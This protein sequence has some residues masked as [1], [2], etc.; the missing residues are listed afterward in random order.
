MAL[1]TL[2]VPERQVLID[3][4]GDAD[5]YNWHH[6]LLLLPTPSPGVWV[7]ATPDW[8]VSRCDLNEH[9]VTALARSSPM[10]GQRARDGIYA[11][12]VPHDAEQLR[13]ARQSA[14]DLL[15]VLGVVS[16]DAAAGET[17][18]WRVAD[19]ALSSFGSE[20]PGEV[21]SDAAQVFGGA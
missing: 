17:G 8:E 13:L 11:F 9:R 6:R 2:D 16:P 18:V 7:A 10:P 20:L 21:V 14:R 12:D 15:E 3:F 1:S 19:P 4:Y 5:G